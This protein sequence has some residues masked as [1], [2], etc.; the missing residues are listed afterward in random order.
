[1]ANQ[2]HVEVLHQGVEAW[3]RWRSEHP[4]IL[5]DLS[6][7][8]INKLDFGG[9]NFE[10]VNFSDAK[11][12]RCNFYEAIFL[13]ANLRHVSFRGSMLASAKL[14]LAD[15]RHA[16][17]SGAELSDSVIMDANL[18]YAKLS[19]IRILGVLLIGSD[20][21]GA[22]LSD[23]TLQESDLSRTKLV[24]ANLRRC[25]LYRTEYEDADLTNADLRAADLTNASFVR[26]K[27]EGANFDNCYV[28][29]I[30][31]WGL[32]GTPTSQKDL[33]IT[34]PGEGIVTTDDLEVAQFIYLMYNNAKIR[35]ILD[36]ATGKGVLI[37]GR[38]TPPERKAVL[39]GLREKLRTYN[40]L[41]IVFDFDRPEHKDYTETVQTLAG[42]SRFVIADV[43]N[44]KS[45]PLELESTVKQF[46]IPYVPII[47]TSVDER[48]FAMIVDLQKNFHWVLPTFAYRSSEELFKHLKVAIID[49][50]IA[51]HNE[52]QEQKAREVTMLTIDDI[53]KSKRKK[54]SP[55]SRKKK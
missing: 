41:P 37:L 53:L 29:G 25:V 45:T 24:N 4:E 33:V 20:L 49:R 30:S 21:T 55:Q 35:K 14:S 11:L 15:L 51:K 10:K 26:T 7:I 6:K 54:R 16:D 52:L 1:M 8:S 46:K 19:G 13:E 32:I 3:N 5:P 31:I 42:M 17:F 39:D 50:A 34:Q 23:S 27:V 12:T 2:K 40:L 28:F 47:D 18:S 48:P 22:D 9:A 43:T 38:F 36:A 44:P